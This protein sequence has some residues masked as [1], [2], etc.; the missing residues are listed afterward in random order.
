VTL[1]DAIPVQVEYFFPIAN[2]FIGYCQH[3]I[4]LK[5]MT[6]KQ[7]YM[8]ASVIQVFFSWMHDGYPIAVMHPTVKRSVSEVIFKTD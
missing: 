4:G 1:Q 6:M 7:W 8:G 5:H 2:L 3:I